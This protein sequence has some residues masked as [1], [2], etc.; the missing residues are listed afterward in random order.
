MWICRF[1]MKPRHQLTCHPRGVK[2]NLTLLRCALVCLSFCRVNLKLFSLFYERDWAFLPAA[3]QSE[4]LILFRQSP[5]IA[6]WQTVDLHNLKEWNSV[7]LFCVCSRPEMRL[8]W[9]TSSYQSSVVD[10]TIVTQK[11]RRNSSSYRTSTISSP[12]AGYMWVKMGKFWPVLSN[13]H[14]PTACKPQNQQLFS[15]VKANPAVL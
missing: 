3:N 2:H 5:W 15:G 12:W 10:R 11:M 1:K 4:Q 8:P 13:N 7:T 9:P 14:R 6:F